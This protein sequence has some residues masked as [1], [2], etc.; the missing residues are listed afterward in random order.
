MKELIKITEHDGRKAVSAR[1]LHAFLESKQEFANWIKSRIDKYGLIENE[2]F[3][4]FDKFIKRRK[5]G[6]RQI[7]Y[8]LSLDCAKE[9][10]M[11]EG[12]SK[13]RQARRYFIE[14]D[15]KYREILSAK[16]I[17]GVSPILY[18]GMVGYPRKELLEAAGYS[19]N[20]GTISELKKEVSRTFFYIIP[21]SL[22][23]TR[24]CQTTL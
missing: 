14:V 7:E 5:G 16:P 4:S 18:K 6:T 11:V 3:S 1:E 2:D 22:Y 12:N 10:A 15:K 9:L 23:I 19:S 17:G 8:V 24:I 13:G 20:S 21:Y